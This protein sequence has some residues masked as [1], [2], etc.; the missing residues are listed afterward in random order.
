MW[1]YVCVG[2]CICVCVCVWYFVCER[3]TLYTLTPLHP[4]AL[5]PLHPYTLSPKP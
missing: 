5:T 1:W 2:A 3:Y 4:Y